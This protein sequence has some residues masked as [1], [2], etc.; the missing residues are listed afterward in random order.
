[1]ILLLGPVPAIWSNEM[2]FSAASFLA[3]GLT[4]ILSPDARLAAYWGAAE[5]EGELAAAATGWAAAY[6]AAA[7]VASESAE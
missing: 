4:N 1:M 6:G 3:R 7:G 5:A 2:P